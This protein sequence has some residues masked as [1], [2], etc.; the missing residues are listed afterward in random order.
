MKPK[1][2][3]RPKR[4]PRIEILERRLQNPHGQPSFPVTLRDPGW[5]CRWFNADVAAD[6][7]WRA[8]QKG[9]EPVTVEEL[10]DPDQIGGYTTTVDRHVARG[11]RSQEVLMKMPTEWRTKIQY[12]KTAEN[13]RVVSNPHRQKQELVEAAG[14]VLGSEGAEALHRHVGVVG[15]VHTNYERIQRLED[16]PA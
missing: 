7:I 1:T 9:W 8:K 13:N 15:D 4:T 16:E 5:E 14:H 12:A 3:E 11:A 10:A 6:H 2:D